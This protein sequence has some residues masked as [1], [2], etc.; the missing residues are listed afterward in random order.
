MRNNK[1]KTKIIEAVA[2]RTAVE[3]DDNN[4]L[5]KVPKI[6]SAF[7]NKPLSLL[8]QSLRKAK[9]KFQNITIEDVTELKEEN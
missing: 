2:F 3:V 5:I 7:L 1:L 8:E 4:N 6:F 9:P